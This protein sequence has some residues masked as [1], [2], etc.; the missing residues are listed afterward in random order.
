MGFT[1]SIVPQVYCAALLRAAQCAA[2]TSK[3]PI[4]KKLIDDAAEALRCSR[5]LPNLY[6][7]VGGAELTLSFPIANVS[8]DSL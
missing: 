8:Y 4:A 5:A 6:A 2:L 3:L 7:Q 1:V